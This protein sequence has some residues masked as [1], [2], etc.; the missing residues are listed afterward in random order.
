MIK[1]ETYNGYPNYETWV[2][3]LWIDNDQSEQ[4][5]WLENTRERLNYAAETDSIATHEK[6]ATYDL[7]EYLKNEFTEGFFETFQIHSDTNNVYIDLMLHELGNVDWL[8]IARHL[9]EDAS[10]VL[11]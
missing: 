4:E 8:T 1:D 7:A 11:S 3:K 10:E 9:I 6:H 5:Y 2:V